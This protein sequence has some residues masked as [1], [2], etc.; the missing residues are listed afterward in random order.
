MQPMC[1]RRR[2]PL[3]SRRTRA[4]ATLCPFGPHAARNIDCSARRKEEQTMADVKVLGAKARGKLEQ[5]AAVLR[6][7][8]GIFNTLFG[9]HQELRALIEKLLATDDEA[10]G[11][12]ARLELIDVVR[13]EMI[14]HARA[15]EREF[16]AVMKQYEETERSA[17]DRLAEHEELERWVEELGS[18][19]PSDPMWMASLESFAAAVERHLRR[20]EEELFP[21]A[22]DCITAEQARQIDQLYRE[23]KLK[24]LTELRRE[25]N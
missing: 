15:E 3:R 2:S 4:V 18:M 16:Y 23:E 11:V 5:A 9:E 25:L 6:G 22:H 14:A 10:P 8:A 17:H 13:M 24:Q 20:E 1:P 21:R 19:P 12:R 7:E